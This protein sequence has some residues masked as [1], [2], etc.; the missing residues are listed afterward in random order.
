MMMMMTM[1]TAGPLPRQ[2]TLRIHG[3]CRKS[4]LLYRS[5]L[6][7]TELQSPLLK[8]LILPL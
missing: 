1:M 4:K 8:I 6:F 5:R 7:V 2:K 3:P